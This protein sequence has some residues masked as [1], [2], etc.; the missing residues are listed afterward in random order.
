MDQ[1]D[2]VPPKDHLDSQSNIY[3]GCYHLFLHLQKDNVDNNAINNLY[4]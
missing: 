4:E 2:E 1:N 3:G